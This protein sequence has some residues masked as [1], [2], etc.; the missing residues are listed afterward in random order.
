MRARKCLWMPAKDVN[1]RNRHSFNLIYFKC[2]NE[3]SLNVNLF[4]CRY[5]SVLV[6]HILSQYVFMGER[7]SWRFEMRTHKH[8]CVCVRWPLV[9]SGRASWC[10]TFAHW[11]NRKRNGKND[12]RNRLPLPDTSTSGQLWLLPP[13]SLERWLSDGSTSATVLLIYIFFKCVIVFAIVVC[14]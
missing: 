3:H 10:L 6:I 11:R 8:T 5:A 12:D 2:N 7:C 13:P 1:C 4:I 14:A 9:A